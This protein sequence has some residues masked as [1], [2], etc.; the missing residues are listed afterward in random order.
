VYLAGS[1]AHGTHTE[2]SDVD[3][4][5][6]FGEAVY[7]TAAEPGG[8]EHR[9]CF[10]ACLFDG[11]GPVDLWIMRPD[12]VPA[13]WYW[14]PDTPRPYLGRGDVPLSQGIRVWFTTTD[15]GVVGCERSARSDSTPRRSSSGSSSGSS[16][17]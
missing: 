14:H 12:G 1:R 2:Y 13:A 7:P 3:L 11:R 4:V 6:L 8:L 9:F 15:D 5:V 10:D 16:A 17:L